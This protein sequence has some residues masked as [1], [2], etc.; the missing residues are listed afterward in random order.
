MADF[1]RVRVEIVAAGYEPSFAR[2][3]GIAHEQLAKV[4]I[5]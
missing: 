4:V 3:S 5:V 2:L 1:Q